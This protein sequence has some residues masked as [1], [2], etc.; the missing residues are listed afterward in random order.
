[1]VDPLWSYYEETVV[2]LFQEP[3]AEEASDTD[4]RQDSLYKLDGK[5]ERA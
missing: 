2:N 3:N 4:V 5:V 1:M